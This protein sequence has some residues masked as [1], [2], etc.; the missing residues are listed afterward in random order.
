MTS[1]QTEIER[2]LEEGVVVFTPTGPFDEMDLEAQFAFCAQFA[3]TH[4]QA[5]GAVFNLALVTRIN[6][7]AIGLVADLATRLEE[8]GRK[9]V[10]AH[11]DKVSDALHICGIDGI[12]PVRG[13]LAQAKKEISEGEASAK[14]AAKA[15]PSDESVSFFSTRP[16]SSFAIGAQAEGLP[17][18][19]KVEPKA[20]PDVVL[21]DEIVPASPARDGGASPKLFSF[22]DQAAAEGADAP[23]AP[24]PAQAAQ[25]IPV[26]V[27]LSGGL[28]D[29]PAP[30]PEK[31][32]APKAEK[33][34]A[35]EPAESAFAELAPQDPAAEMRAILEEAAAK[36]ESKVAAF[37]A[38]RK[39]LQ[40][41]AAAKRS[42]AAAFQSEAKAHKAE[43]KSLEKEAA[44]IQAALK[45]VK[46]AGA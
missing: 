4:S 31:K 8:S 22:L 44:R 43:A 17:A 34:P 35:P 10:L 1:P 16:S 41:A 9:L 26:T 28:F 46:T 33:R 29:A 23:K 30:K 40:E 20:E 3:E 5:K 37:D 11:A 12:I 2:H 14:P 42:R 39:D 18:P 32:P 7:K 24:V 19:K 27:S 38:R 25:E 15:A 36:L 21:E 45:S 13:T 6:S